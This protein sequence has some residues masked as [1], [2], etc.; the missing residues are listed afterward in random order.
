[1]TSEDIIGMVRLPSHC[2]KLC[3]VSSRVPSG[4]VISKPLELDLD[5]ILHKIKQVENKIDN[6]VK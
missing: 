6:N 1:L 5:K 2:G 4:S 3:C